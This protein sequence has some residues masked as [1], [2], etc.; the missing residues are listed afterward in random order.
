MNLKDFFAQKENPPELYWS[1]VIEPG[2]VQAGIWHMKEGVAD[3]IA[4]SPTTA[5]EGDGELLGATDA[6]LSSAVAKLPEKFTEPTKT[7]FGVGSS[8][9]KGGEI[10]EVH[11]AKIKKICTE[12]SLVPTGFVILPEA[13]AHLIKSEEGAPANAVI[14]GLGKEFLDIS[15]FSLGNLVGSATVARSVSLVDDVIEGLS[16]FGGVGTLPSR[17]IV[18]DGR[19]GELD[20]ARDALTGASW[21][22]V[23]GVK[24][25]HT[26]KVEILDS[27]K[28]ILATS[29]AGAAELGGVSGVSSTGVENISEVK[30][31]PSAEELGFVVGGDVSQ[32]P[33]TLPLPTIPTTPPAP[34][35]SIK[36][37]DHLRGLFAKFSF[38][39]FDF[40]NKKKLYLWGVILGVFLVG[41]VCYWWFYPK[42]TVAIYVSPK[43]F[44][45]EF[46]ISFDA[47]ELAKVDVSGEKTK[48]VSGIKLVGEKAKG[49]IS[50]RN[51]TASAINFPGGTILVSSGD[52]RFTLDNTAS[53]SAAIDADNPGTASGDVIAADIGA[54][55]NLA[56]DEVFKIGNY[57]KADAYAKSTADFSGGSSREISA[58]AGEDREK[59]LQDLTQEL[60]E[61]SKSEFLAKISPDQIFVDSLVSLKTQEESFSHKVGDEAD[62]LKLNLSVNAE[63]IISDRQKLADVVRERLKE[64]IPQ[65]FV[66]RDSQIGYE[67]EFVG[68]NE[69][70]YDFKV[71][72][73][74][75]FLPEVKS[76]EIVAKVSG[77]LPEVVEKYLSEV[78]GFSRAEIHLTPRFPGRFGTLPRVRKNIT[79]EIVAEK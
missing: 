46:D 35:P 24:F 43:K 9:V 39:K 48:S 64:T 5:W 67:F 75:N 21:E 19:E 52:L 49:A 25:L 30:K 55:Y 10:A 54:A 68:E 31:G 4:V 29:L 26:P 11:L 37:L 36:I 57:P 23:K 1:L 16:R 13:V 74:V 2:W 59:L 34:P 77:R 27:D 7:V 41:L 56:K 33:A 14:L 71:K 73:N 38:P 20:E 66:L 62:T 63:G 18:F 69:G 40:P 72:V 8:W 45:E 76:E 58:V 65:G 70:K 22:E 78:P 51:G 50:L 3:I 32:T 47:N 28:K 79:I 44:E 53:V 42:A 12:L 15:V 6:A 60:T 17:I 61:K